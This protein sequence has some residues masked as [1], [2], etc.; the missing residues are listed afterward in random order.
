M[1][2]QLLSFVKLMKISLILLIGDPNIKI[3]MVLRH[4]MS[5]NEGTATYF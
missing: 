4:N 1:F 3:E 2:Y 5:K